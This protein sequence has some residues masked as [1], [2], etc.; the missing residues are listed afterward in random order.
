MTSKLSSRKFS[1]PTRFEIEPISPEIDKQDIVL[2]LD[3][4][5]VSDEVISILE[6]AVA[7]GHS[8]SILN[9]LPGSS[10]DEFNE[11]VVRMIND[12]KVRLIAMDDRINCKLLVLGHLSVFQFPSPLP[13]SISYERI[14]IVSNEKLVP[15][16]YTLR[17][18]RMESLKGALGYHAQPI[19]FS[20][21]KKHSPVDLVAATWFSDESANVALAKEFSMRIV[22]RK[23]FNVETE[24]GLIA[25]DLQR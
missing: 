23:T 14:S 24:L 4:T 9:I 19:D 10:W 18:T 22:P 16:I 21:I 3:L 12:F 11:S 17:S 1:C 13:W 6:D 8:V 2:V 20:K 7:L 5:S 25:R 15:K